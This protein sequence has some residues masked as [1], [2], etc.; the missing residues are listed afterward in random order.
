MAAEWISRLNGHADLI[1]KLV[2]EVPKAL[3]RPS[4]TL[5][6]GERLHAVIEKGAHDFEELLQI[7][8]QK[9]VDEQYR[10]TAENLA[11][12]WKRLSN[13]VE[14]KVRSMIVSDQTSEYDDEASPELNDNDDGDRTDIDHRDKTYIMKQ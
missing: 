2:Q 3:A 6:Q 1:Q 4:L 12:T 8:D 5:E 9:D 10:E 14:A 7:M 13:E 11:R